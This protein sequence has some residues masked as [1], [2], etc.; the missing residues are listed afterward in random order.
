[1][2]PVRQRVRR[3]LTLR[4]PQ[5]VAV[6]RVTGDADVAAAEGTEQVDQVALARVEA[7][8]AEFALLVR[9]ADEVAGQPAARVRAVDGGRG[10]G[11]GR[12]RRIRRER[13][14]LP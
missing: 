11:G 6:E 10:L 9:Q 13:R 1:L 12:G 2:H 14:R 5:R 8:D 4:Y 3:L 7:A